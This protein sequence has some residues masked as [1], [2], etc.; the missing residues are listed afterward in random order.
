MIRWITKRYGK[1]KIQRLSKKD[2]R[3]RK[4]GAVGRSFKLD[5]K[6]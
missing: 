2:N 5:V 1:H 6:K 3:E 4:F